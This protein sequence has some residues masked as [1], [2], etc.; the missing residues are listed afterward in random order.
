M[1]EYLFECFYNIDGM[2]MIQRVLLMMVHNFPSQHAD[3]VIQE[4]CTLI[5]HQYIWAAKPG[6]NILKNESCR[7]LYNTMLNRH[8][9]CPL[10]Q[11]FLCFRH[12]GGLIIPTKSITH[13][14]NGFST[15]T[16]KIAVHI[17]L[18]AS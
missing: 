5:S 2:L 13:F 9:F 12:V 11:I 4:V 14:S 8:S 16:R 18:M 15:V 3:G 1:L 17:I 10:G 6:D 7:S